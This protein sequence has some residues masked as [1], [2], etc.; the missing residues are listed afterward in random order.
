MNGG[1]LMCKLEH[2]DEADRA[3]HDHTGGGI[4]GL[5]VS[6][7]RADGQGEYSLEEVTVTGG[8]I[9]LWID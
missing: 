6:V 2:I 9:I 7:R 8:E 4:S 1:E 3:F 5:R